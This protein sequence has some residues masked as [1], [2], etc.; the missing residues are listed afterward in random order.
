[1]T[2]GS[3][4]LAMLDGHDS[5]LTQASNRGQQGDKQD[6][7]QRS[8]EDFDAEARYKRSLSPSSSPESKQQKFDES[9]YAW[10]V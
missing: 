6:G 1:M 10:K 7:G 9:L 4:Y 2:A 3:T 5:L 8:E